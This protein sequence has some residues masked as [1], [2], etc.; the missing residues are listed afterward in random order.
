MIPDEFWIRIKSVQRI[1]QRLYLSGRGWIVGWLILLLEHKGRKTGRLYATPLQYERIQDDFYIGAARG[2]RSDWFRNL[3]ADPCVHV[4]VGRKEFDAVA[5][6]VTDL[7][8]SA[9]FLEY[10]LRRHPLMI[11]L[12]MKLHHL[13]MRPSRLQLEQLASRL[14]MVILHPKSLREREWPVHP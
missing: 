9:D 6:P 5:E 11:G 2:L 14:A 1:H 4:R 10:R 7:S 3:Q 13:P 8:R 12:M